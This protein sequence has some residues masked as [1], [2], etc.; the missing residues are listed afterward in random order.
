MPLCP[1]CGEEEELELLEVW[2]S[3]EFMISTCCEQ[4]EEEARWGLSE[5]PAWARAALR[6]LGIEEICG[7]TLRRVADDG[8]GGL[9]LDWLQVRPDRLPRRA[10]LHQ[11]PP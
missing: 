2:S 1:H 9:I 4:S 10:P 5:D 7:E 8:C 6:R 11:S 3:R